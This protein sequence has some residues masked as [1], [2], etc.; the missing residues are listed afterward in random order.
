MNIGTNDVSTK[1]IGIGG[2]SAND[3]T[4]AFVNTVS[5]ELSNAKKRN[6]LITG[7]DTKTRRVYLENADGTRK[8]VDEKSF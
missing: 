2:L 6:F 4:N 1:S 7:Y 5:A 3:V 8:Y